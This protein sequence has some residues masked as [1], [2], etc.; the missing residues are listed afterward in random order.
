MLIKLAQRDAFKREMETLSHCKLPINHQ[1]YQLDPVLHDGVLRVGGR[2]KKALSPLDLKHPIILLKESV[3]TRLI[4]G[5]CHEKIQ[6]QR[7]GQTLNELRA[8]GYW[9]VGDSKVVAN[10]INQCVT[11]RR[12]RSL[13]EIQMMADLPVNRVDPSPH[14]SYCGMNCF[15]PFY[16]KQGRKQQ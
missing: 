16:T 11:C 14:F 4:L 8:N 15:E 7:R 3:V 13:T 2:L 6:H 10:H 5:H 1:L 12:A 9:I